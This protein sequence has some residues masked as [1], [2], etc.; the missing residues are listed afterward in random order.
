M[1]EGFVEASCFGSEETKF[2]E[3]AGAFKFSEAFAGDE[4]VGVFDGGDNGFNFSVNEG[5]GARRGFTVVAAGFEVNVESRAFG[6]VAGF[7][8]CDDFG[9][10]FAGAC[11][12]SVA[13]DFAVFDEYGADEGVG[14]SLAAGAGGERNSASHEMDVVFGEFIRH[15]EKS[16]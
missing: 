16:S 4:W 5:V 1:D 14:S 9:V 12:V 15:W 13:D 10:G 3:D 11:V 2:N 6:V 8:E 7:I